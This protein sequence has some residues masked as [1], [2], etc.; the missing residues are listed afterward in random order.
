[1]LEEFSD[2]CGYTNKEVDLCFA[3]HIQEWAD[4]RDIPYMQIRE[5]LALWYNGYCFKENC[6][7]VYSPFSLTCALDIKELHNF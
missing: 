2:I 4:L 7:K 5:N 3:K 1:M 6:A